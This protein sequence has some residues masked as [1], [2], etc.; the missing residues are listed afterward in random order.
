MFWNSFPRSLRFLLNLPFIVMLKIKCLFFNKV[1]CLI[2]NTY[3]LSCPYTPYCFGI[4][5]LLATGQW[6]WIKYFISVVFFLYSFI[7]PSQWG[8]NERIQKENNRKEI[9][10]FKNTVLVL[11]GWSL[12]QWKWIEGGRTVASSCCRSSVITTFARHRLQN[13][14]F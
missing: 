2:L 9:L 7:P 10:N 11:T 6:R 4:L 14:N 5:G 13:L 3:F 8:W 12:D 1:V